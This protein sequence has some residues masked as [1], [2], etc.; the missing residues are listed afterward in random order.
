MIYDVAVIK[1]S[2]GNKLSINKRELDLP[3]VLIS[4]PNSSPYLE[5]ELIAFNVLY[6]A[7]GYKL[8]PLETRDITHKTC[9]YKRDTSMS[10]PFPNPAK[11]FDE[12]FSLSPVN[13]WDILDQRNPLPVS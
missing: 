1:H 12:R 8:T 5:V 9:R 7:E 11:M 6:S 2:I 13:V 3:R 10:Q 4:K